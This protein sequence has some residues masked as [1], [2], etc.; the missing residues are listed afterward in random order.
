MIKAYLINLDRDQERLAFFS[1]NFARLGLAFERV[2]AVDGRTFSDADYQAF[3]QAR[4]RPTKPWYRGQMGCFLSHF[5][6]WRRIAEG[7]DRVCAVFEDDVH[8]SDD[9][10]RVLAED[11]W[12]PEGVDIVRLETSPN[13]VRL[14]RK[15]FLTCHD[16][17][18]Y[19][20]RSTSWCAGGYL[21][22]RH[23]AQRLISL[24][25]HQHA[26]T[27]FLLFSHADSAI[28]A[29]LTTLQ[30]EPALCTQ[31]KYHAGAAMRFS[32]NI[33]GPVNTKRALRLRLGRFSPMNLAVAVARSLQDY[34]RIGFR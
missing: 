32:S 27:D 18:A 15:P 7:E 26:P 14:A 19:Q 6:A 11:S 2:A 16:R 33:D 31:D 23:T 8:V 5:E 28:A 34:R 30:F 3:N 12:L 20:V 10:P 1:A 17:P 9:L 21:I 13:R 29:Q 4:P 25:P 24:P 22:S